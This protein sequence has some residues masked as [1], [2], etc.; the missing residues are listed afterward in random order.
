MMQPS[1]SLVMMQSSDEAITAAFS[2]P[3]ARRPSSARFLSVMSAVEPATRSTRLVTPSR[4][5]APVVETQRRVPSDERT[6]YSSETV[7][8]RLFRKAR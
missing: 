6:R 5:A 2:D 7:I 3:D 8:D 4:T 1:A